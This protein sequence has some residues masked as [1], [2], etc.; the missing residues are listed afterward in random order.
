MFGSLAP[1]GIVSLQWTVVGWS[2][3]FSGDL[4]EMGI[5]GDLKKAFLRYTSNEFGLTKT[6]FQVSALT[7]CT[8]R[9]SV[10]VAAAS[11][12]YGGGI[13]RIRPGAWMI[14]VVLWTTVVFDPLS[15]MLWSED[16][17]LYNYGVKDFAG[18]LVVHLNAGVSGLMLTILLGPRDR[19]RKKHP[20]HPF[21]LSMATLGSGLLWIA[22]LGMNGGSALGSTEYAVRGVLNTQLAMCAAVLTWFILERIWLGHGTLTSFMSGGLAGAA[23]AASFCGYTNSWWAVLN[24]IL[25]GL[26]CY[27]CSQF[28]YKFRY[29]DQVDLFGLHAVGGIVGSITC[30]VYEIFHEKD[31]GALGRQFVGI[32]IVILWS[33]IMTFLI[34]LCIHLTS[35]YA[36]G[37]NLR[38]DPDEEQEGIDSAIH[39]QRVY[40]SA[41]VP[42]GKVDKEEQQRRDGTGLRISGGLFGMGG[43]ADNQT[44]LLSETNPLASYTSA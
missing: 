8:F 20:D 28:K 29:D 9:L 32:A 11:L 38:V 27:I 13:G 10:A 6:G 24:G 40:Y 19:F 41:A 4:F 35:H 12:V 43:G 26:M 7:E 5:V 23:S 44:P 15:F 18:G 30:G 39:K 22:N 33:A 31:S 17:W 37:S 14:F 36:L 42:G 16:G 34:V 21:N 3:C 1:I 25:V 2:L